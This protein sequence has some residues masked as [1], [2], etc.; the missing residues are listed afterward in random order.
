M[1]KGIILLNGEEQNQIEFNYA[2]NKNKDKDF[3][4]WDL[5]PQINPDCNYQFECCKY[6]IEM[7][8]QQDKKYLLIIHNPNKKLTRRLEDDYPAYRLNI[9]TKI[10]LNNPFFELDPNDKNFNEDSMKL[11]CGLFSNK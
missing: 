2:L 1:L 4:L 6:F 10:N 11:V 5:H 3:S 8:K 9:T 7:I